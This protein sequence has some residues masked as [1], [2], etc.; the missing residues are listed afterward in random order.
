VRLDAGG[1]RPEEDMREIS[2]GQAGYD[3]DA[4]FGLLLAD[5]GGDEGDG[6]VEIS[7]KSVR[8]RI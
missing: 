4:M 1:E 3:Q 2:A 5:V 8:A 6:V 7:D